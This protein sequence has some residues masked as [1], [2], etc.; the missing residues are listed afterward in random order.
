MHTH[1]GSGPQRDELT[2]TSTHPA[3]GVHLSWLAKP[4]RKTP[5]ESLARALNTKFTDTEAQRASK[6]YKEG[7]TSPGVKEAPLLAD[8]IRKWFWGKNC[9]W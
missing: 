7:A 5:R 4:F 6:S 3:Q 8:Q 2:G 1:D 9:S